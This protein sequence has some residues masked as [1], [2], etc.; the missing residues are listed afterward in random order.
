[1]PRDRLTFGCDHLTVDMTQ[2]AF[3]AL[4]VLQPGSWPASA[5]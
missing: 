2:E 4:P 3:S 1:V 5:Q